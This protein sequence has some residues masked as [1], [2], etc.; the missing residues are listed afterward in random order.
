MVGLRALCERDGKSNRIISRLARE[1]ILLAS[2]IGITQKE[3][4]T[5]LS[6]TR[7]VSAVNFPNFN[8]KRPSEQRAFC[9]FSSLEAKNARSSDVGLAADGGGVGSSGKKGTAESRRPRELAFAGS[10][11]GGVFYCVENNAVAIA[12][13]TWR[14]CDQRQLLAAN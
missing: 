5:P 8:T 11:I 4:F 3:L 9:R 7:S 10:G 1:R 2:V 6:S 12:F 14:V 13:S